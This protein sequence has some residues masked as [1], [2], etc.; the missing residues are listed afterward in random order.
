MTRSD[1]DDMSSRVTTSSNVVLGLEDL[2]AYDGPTHYEDIAIELGNNR[3]KFEDTRTRLIDTALQRNPM[4]SY[5]DAS[6]RYTKNLE[7]DWFQA[8]DRFLSGQ[9]PEEIIIVESEE[10][11]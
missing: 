4:H 3:T 11:V 1:G 8:W 6:S 7:T 2:N 10:A 9:D 5:W